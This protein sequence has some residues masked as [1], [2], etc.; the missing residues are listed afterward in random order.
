[1]DFVNSMKRQ[2]LPRTIWE[3]VPLVG[4]VWVGSASQTVPR[5][6]IFIPPPPA[7]T[8]IPRPYNCLTVII[9]NPQQGWHKGQILESIRQFCKLSQLVS[10]PSWWFK[11]RCAFFYIIF[12]H[13]SHWFTYR[14][15]VIGLTYR[16]SNFICW[17]EKIQMVLTMLP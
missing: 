4:E 14:I 1:M 15:L 17:V 10:F 16:I 6:V 2:N 12:V 5:Q 13:A 3:A 11:G 9:G 7:P 8:S